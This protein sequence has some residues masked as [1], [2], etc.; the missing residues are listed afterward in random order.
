ME[1]SPVRRGRLLVRFAPGVAALGDR[2]MEAQAGQEAA[3]REYIQDAAGSA[4]SSADELD[5]L[6]SLHQQGVLTD[7][8]FQAQKAKL[9]T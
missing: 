2:A 9:L 5:K 3:Q 4:G 6:A 7:E 8:E 1:P